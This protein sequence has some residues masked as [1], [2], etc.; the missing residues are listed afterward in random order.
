MIYPPKS[1]IS[2]IFHRTSPKITTKNVGK[3]YDFCEF[4][5]IENMSILAWGKNWKS[6]KILNRCFTINE[7]FEIEKIGIWKT[8]TFPNKDEHFTIL[9]FETRFLGSGTYEIWDLGFFKVGAQPSRWNEFNFSSLIL[10]HLLLQKDTEYR[11]LI[12]QWWPSTSI[13]DQLLL[14]RV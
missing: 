14:K 13:D 6:M 8:K 10:G 12:L 2:T 11:V 5:P 3:K 1:L 4:L 7:V 9:F